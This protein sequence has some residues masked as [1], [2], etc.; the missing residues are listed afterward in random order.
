MD[1]SVK[2]YDASRSDLF[3]I[4]QPVGMS[5]IICSAAD[6]SWAGFT[7]PSC[8]AS[9]PRM[10]VSRVPASACASTLGSMSPS[11]CASAMV[12]ASSPRHMEYAR[13]T[14]SLHV[15]VGGTEFR[16]CPGHHAAAPGL[17]GG[18]GARLPADVAGQPFVGAVPGVVQL[19]IDGVKRCGDVVIERPNEQSVL[20]A[21]RPVEA[22]LAEAGGGRRG[23]RPMSHRSRV[24]RTRRGRPR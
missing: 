15:V 19:R 5:A 2:N 18:G 14:L 7:P 13:S 24:S 17:V 1:H 6:L 16:R 8:S 11:R 3:R 12:S 23:R 22:A 4:G 21:E 9:T 20:V 10:N